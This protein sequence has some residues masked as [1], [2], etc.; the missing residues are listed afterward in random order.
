MFIG[1]F[2]PDEVDSG[3]ELASCLQAVKKIQHVE[4]IELINLSIEGLNFV[5]QEVLQREESGRN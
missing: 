2:R 4:E 1:A 5:V 3:G